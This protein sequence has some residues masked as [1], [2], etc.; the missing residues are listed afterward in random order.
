MFHLLIVDDDRHIRFVLKELLELEGYTIFTA[1]NGEE[2]LNTIFEKHIDLVI[3]DIM[4]PKLDGYEFTKAVRSNN[5]DLP[6]LMISAK[7]LPE[8]RKK[9]FISGIDDFMTKPIDSEE[10]LLHIKAL[11]RRAKNNNEKQI[12]IGDV[13]LDYDSY[14]AS[15]LDEK[16]ELPQ[17]EFQLLFKL[18]SFPNK[19]F[20]RIQLM[21]EFWGIYTNSE[22]RT[23]D[24]H[25]NRLRD[26]FRNNPDFEII[27]IRGLGYKA[28]K[29]G[30]K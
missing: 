11:L 9:G 28:V 24:T 14:T 17:K 22:E 13:I 15:R 3:V 1:K 8:D 6:I 4:M 30:G 20:T 23:V 19:I 21:D 29:H 5:I 7:Q 10:L 12:I 25:I 2:A 27:T 16:I 18:L 26:K